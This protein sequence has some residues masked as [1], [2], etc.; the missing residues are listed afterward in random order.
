[1]HRF[2]HLLSAATNLL[3]FS[4]VII[5]ALKLTNS[6]AKSYSDE[7]AWAASG[8][9]LVVIVCSYLVIRRNQTNVAFNTLAD[10]AFLGGLTMLTVSLAIGASFI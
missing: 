7:C 10:F 3:G 8:L 6:D 4:F 5:G 2:P 9:F 1:M